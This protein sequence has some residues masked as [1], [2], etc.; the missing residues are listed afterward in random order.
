MERSAVGERAAEEQQRRVEELVALQQ[1]AAVRLQALQRGNM[2]R[3]EAAALAELLALQQ[4][5]AVK[6]QVPPAR[7]P[8]LRCVSRIAN[9]SCCLRKTALDG[10]G[11]GTA[12][13]WPTVPPPRPN[14]PCRH[15]PPC[16]LPLPCPL[17]SLPPP[18]LCSEARWRAPR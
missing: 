14:A 3:E 1:E 11:L 2:G 7:L 8:P 12:A 17:P 6:L 5:A 15:V 16:L 4:Q 18:R 13:V 9:A 10:V